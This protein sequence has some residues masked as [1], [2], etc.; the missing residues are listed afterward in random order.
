[1]LQR[2]RANVHLRPARA[3]DIAR[4]V[5][6]LT[7]AF[8]EPLR[9]DTWQWI[10]EAPEGSIFV[11]ERRSEIIGTGAGLLFGDTGWIGGL[12][13]EPGSRRRGIASRLTTQV[14][15]WLREQGAQ[16]L[17]L[18]ATAQGQP[19]YE[20]LG[21]V[22]EGAYRMWA[23]PPARSARRRVDGGHGLRPLRASDLDAVLQLDREVTGEDRGLAVRGAWASG[24]Y[25][26][27]DGERLRGYHLH[28]P[29]GPGPTVAADPDA[30]LALLEAAQ[31]RDESVRVGIPEANAT[32][33]RA[34]TGR[35][36][37]E[38]PGTQR[39]RLGPPVTWRPDLVF[40]VFNPFWG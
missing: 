18:Q 35:G 17:L 37:E 20:Q 23:V 24:G 11:A 28:T 19:V 1:M 8:G 30:G 13:V 10:L 4:V 32:A 33:A 39:M 22:A 6:T 34:M 9:N 36:Y 5:R 7:L 31:R 40:G 2:A 16:T 14:V 15:D 21:F 29:W 38:V 27:E 12:G 26:L 25:A 3:R